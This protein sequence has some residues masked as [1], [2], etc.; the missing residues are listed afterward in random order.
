M[1]KCFLDGHQ[2]EDLILYVPQEVSMYILSKRS[3]MFWIT[4]NWDV[5]NT[6]LWQ[7]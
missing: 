2:R 6:V 7:N 3:N 4:R 5:L 1:D